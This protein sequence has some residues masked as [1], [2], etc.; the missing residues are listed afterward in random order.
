MWGDMGGA[1]SFAIAYDDA[2]HDDEPR[3]EAAPRA[4][5]AKEKKKQR[6]KSRSTRANE[7]HARWRCAIA[8]H[9]AAP[10]LGD[11]GIAA[12]ASIKSSTSAFRCGVVA[13][14]HESAPRSWSPS[15]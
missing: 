15:W 1:P 2:V 8:S 7:R 11:G 4:E 12:R 3:V 10:A 9:G 14:S 13:E 5:A 6:N